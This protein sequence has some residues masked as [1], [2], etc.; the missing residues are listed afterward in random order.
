MLLAVGSPL[1]G[2]FYRAAVRHKGGMDQDG[3]KSGWLHNILSVDEYR[4]AGTMMVENSSV[5]NCRFKVS[6]VR[7]KWGASQ[8][9]EATLAS[10]NS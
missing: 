6:R 5:T 7:V 1:G 4:S 3:C 9:V 2:G 10:A 8:H